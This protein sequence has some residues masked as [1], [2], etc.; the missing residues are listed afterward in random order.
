MAVGNRAHLYGLNMVGLRRRGLSREEIRDIKRSYEII[1][2]SSLRL[3]D[4]TE[5]L[6]EELPDSIHAKR[7]VEFIEGAERGVARERS[8]KSG[9]QGGE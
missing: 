7:F 3:R 2:R 9:E 6:R 5:K 8:K 1:F 4:A